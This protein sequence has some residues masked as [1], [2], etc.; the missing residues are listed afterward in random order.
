MVAEMGKPLKAIEG[1]CAKEA[2]ASQGMELLNSSVE[3][4]PLKVVVCFFV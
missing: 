2:F 1:G 4:I 3:F